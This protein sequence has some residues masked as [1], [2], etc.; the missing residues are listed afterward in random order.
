[1]L[2]DSILIE[3]PK[4]EIFWKTGG[5]YNLNFQQVT[6]TNW[7]AGGTGSFAINTGMT[8]FANYK[9]ESKVWDKTKRIRE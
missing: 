2:G 7:A 4:K 3:E 6:L 9:K 8:L 5:N 1:M